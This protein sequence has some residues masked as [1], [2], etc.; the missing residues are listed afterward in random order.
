LEFLGDVLAEIRPTGKVMQAIGHPAENG[1]PK[2][3][4]P[5]SL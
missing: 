3:I 5:A 4:F 2:R 1:W